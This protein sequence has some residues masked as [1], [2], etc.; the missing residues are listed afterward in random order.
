MTNNGTEPG[1][2]QYVRAVVRDNGGTALMRKIGIP[3]LLVEVP[4]TVVDLKGYVVAGQVFWKSEDTKWVTSRCLMAFKA[5]T[6]LEFMLCDPG[7]HIPETTMEVFIAPSHV[8]RSIR[9]GITASDLKLQ[10]EKDQLQLPFLL[11]SGPVLKNFLGEMQKKDWKSKVE[12]LEKM[13]LMQ[14]QE[15]DKL[16]SRITQLE[17]KLGVGS[18]TEKTK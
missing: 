9:Q 16:I 18:I 3:T 2:S 1:H 13:I 7:R 10:L 4:P 6:A 8:V 11:N 12:S 15:N 5:S 14:K 17:D